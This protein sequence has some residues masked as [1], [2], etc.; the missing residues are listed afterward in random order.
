MQGEAQEPAAGAWSGLVW[1][2]SAF[3]NNKCQP[4]IKGNKT[5]RLL[6]RSTQ[7]PFSTI[8]GPSV[9]SRC[10]SRHFEQHL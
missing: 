2:L 10:C 4:G 9:V 7:L 1:M 5:S 3:I 6:C 8:S